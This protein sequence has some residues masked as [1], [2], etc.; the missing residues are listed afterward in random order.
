MFVKSVSSLLASGLFLVVISIFSSYETVTSML[1]QSSPTETDN[2]ED[3]KSGNQEFEILPPEPFCDTNLI[4]ATKEATEEHNKAPMIK[5]GISSQISY[6][7]T[8]R[9]TSGSAS[10]G[11]SL[12]DCLR[13]AASDVEREA[14]F[15]KNKSEAETSNSKRTVRKVKISKEESSSVGGQAWKNEQKPKASE[16]SEPNFEKS[17]KP[18][19]FP[20]TKTS[21]D[22]N[23]ALGLYSTEDVLLL[24]QVNLDDIASEEHLKNANEEPEEIKPDLQKKETYVIPLVL[25]E[26]V[27]EELEFEVGQED[28]GTVWLAELYMDE[29]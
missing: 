18:F 23:N 8:R 4:K 26:T 17:R 12:V 1:M 16:S 15:L 10:S 6:D 9:V 28:V 19:S 7:E 21:P 27:E 24:K 22:N 5:E 13:L 3:T 25:S 14:E 2:P 20:E 29:G 11:R